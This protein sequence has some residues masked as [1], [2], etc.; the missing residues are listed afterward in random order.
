MGKIT[1]EENTTLTPLDDIGYYCGVCWGSGTSNRNRNITRAKECLEAGHMRTAEFP[2]VYM[3][4]EGYSARVIRELYTHIGG[5]PTR[6]Q[7]STRYI[8]Y[9]DFKYV[10]PPSIK[11]NP[12]ALAIYERTM[13]QISEGM[14]DLEALNIPKEDISM[15]LPLG[16]ETKVVVRTNL[17]NLIDMAHQRMC[18]RAYWEFRELMNDI[19]NALKDYSDEWKEIVSE[20]FKPKCYIG[21]CTEKKSCGLYRNFLEN[22][23]SSL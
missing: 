12:Q 10:I 11:R 1:I 7:A 19:I 8:N 5:M 15:M 22:K 23:I 20:Y 17:R 3:T 6:L 4:L 18:T 16:M 21:K 2:Q 14:K 9:D 13:Y